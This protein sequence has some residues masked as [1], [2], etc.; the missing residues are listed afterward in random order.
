MSLKYFPEAPITPKTP[1]PLHSQSEAALQ[2]V[3]ELEALVDG[4]RP[5]RPTPAGRVAASSRPERR[6]A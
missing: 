5:A 6:A 2:R 3:L 4:S 1:H